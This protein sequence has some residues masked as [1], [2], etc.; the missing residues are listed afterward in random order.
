MTISV[1]WLLAGVIIG[2]WGMWLYMIRQPDNKPRKAGVID[3]YEPIR[4]R[5]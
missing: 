2:A 4:K 5:A 3:I 1:R